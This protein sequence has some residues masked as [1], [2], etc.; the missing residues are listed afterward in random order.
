M[1]IWLVIIY[2][3][4]LLFVLLLFFCIF[5]LGFFFLVIRFINMNV[6]FIFRL[7][8][9]IERFLRRKVMLM[10]KILFERIIFFVLVF[11]IIFV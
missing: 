9:R 8:V 2:W 4:W 11:E 5:V 3:R 6:L 7:I 10:I 1:V